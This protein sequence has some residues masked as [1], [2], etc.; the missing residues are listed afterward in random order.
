M[1]NVTHTY[2][3]GGVDWICEQWVGASSMG[4]GRGENPINFPL[5]LLLLQISAVSLFSAFFQFLLRPFGKFVFLTQILVSMQLEL[6]V[7]ANN[8]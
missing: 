1:A 7:H 5:P 4:V 8:S 2:K 3:Y 6:L